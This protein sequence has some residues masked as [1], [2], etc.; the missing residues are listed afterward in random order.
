MK[1]KEGAVYHIKDD[2]LDLAQGYGVKSKT[3]SGH[4]Y[5]AYCCLKDSDNGVFWMIPIST[6]I[7]KYLGIIAKETEKYGRCCSIVI[8]TY[9]MKK[10]AFQ[11]QGMFPVKKRHIHHEHTRKG[12]AVAVSSEI[13]G[14][15]RCC[16]DIAMEL[17]NRGITCTMTDIFSLARLFS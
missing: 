11:I 9:D 17:N 14:E 6:N 7:E 15:I 8:G 3:D 10:V 12:K 4:T 13:R 16:F 1:I 2:Y 5:P